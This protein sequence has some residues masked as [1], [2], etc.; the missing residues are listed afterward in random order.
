MQ[1]LVAMQLVGG[2]EALRAGLAGEGT[3]ARVDA[4]VLLGT[5]RA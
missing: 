1:R 2:L 4:A 5:G 3:L